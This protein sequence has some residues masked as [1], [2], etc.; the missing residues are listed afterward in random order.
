MRYEEDRGRAMYGSVLMDLF[1]S[2]VNPCLE[3]HKGFNNVGKMVGSH[4]ETSE[5]FW[6]HLDTKQKNSSCRFP[7]VQGQGD[8]DRGQGGRDRGQEDRY[9]DRAQAGRST[10]YTD[11]AEC[12]FSSI[13]IG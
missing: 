3:C 4:R 1:G 10:G 12:S 5:E 13:S 9:P 6:S 7:S 2:L 8:R 11:T